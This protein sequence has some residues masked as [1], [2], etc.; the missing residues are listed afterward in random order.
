MFPQIIEEAKKEYEEYMEE[1]FFPVERYGDESEN[2]FAHGD[3]LSFMKY[4]IKEKDMKG[5]IKVIYTDPPFFTKAK[6]KAVIPNEEGESVKLHAYSDRWEEGSF[7]YYKMIC[8]RLYAMKDLLAEDGSIWIHLDWHASHYMKV[9][10]DEIFGEKNFINEVIWTYKSGGSTKR[11]FAR[12]HDNLLFYGKSKD[13]LFN[14]QKEKSYNRGFAPYRFKNVEE[15]EDE[16]GWYTLVNMKDVWNIDMVGRTSGERTGYATQKP[17]ALIDRIIRSC[18]NEG[19]IC[20][21]FFAGSGTLASSAASLDRRF[22][23]CDSGDLAL[24]MSIKRLLG[25]EISFDVYAKEDKIEEKN[26]DIFANHDIIQISV[27]EKNPEWLDMWSVDTDFNGIIH[28]PGYVFKRSKKDI[29]TELLLHREQIN[30]FE[31][32]EINLGKL[33]SVVIYTTAGNR[34]HMILDLD[35]MEK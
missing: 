3:C 22:I 8:A 15:F 33:V 28:R 11:R 30:M 27:F 10:M 6:Y 26:D 21:D 4:L 13:Y 2:I 5:R 12:K 19:D 31:C 24:E 29:T 17:K 35:H 7:E 16:V 20:A 18:T 32:P 25:Q 9:L 1:D 14:P 34:K 23:C